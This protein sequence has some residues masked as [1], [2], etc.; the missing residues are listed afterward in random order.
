MPGRHK[1]HYRGD[2]SVISPNEC[3]SEKKETPPE[4]CLFRKICP[5]G[6]T[7]TRQLSRWTSIDSGTRIVNKAPEGAV[8]F[9]PTWAFA[10]HLR[11]SYL[12]PDSV[13]PPTPLT[14]VARFYW[15]GL[16]NA[17][18]VERLFPSHPPATFSGMY[19]YK[20]PFRWTAHQELDLIELGERPARGLKSE[21]G[22]MA[23][24]IVAGRAF[25]VRRRV[26]VSNR[27]YWWMGW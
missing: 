9:E 21:S 13:T 23:E 16:R 6:F 19:S 27:R 1:R 12:R 4:G 24:R 3:S 20:P 5:V 17:R 10:S 11:D 8:G 15:L 18:K 25:R 2:T 7:P 14:A 22:P 26:R